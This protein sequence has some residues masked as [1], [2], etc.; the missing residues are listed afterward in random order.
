MQQ[1][2]KNISKERK[3]TSL[4]SLNEDL[5]VAVWQN[6]TCSNDDLWNNN[7]MIVNFFSLQSTHKIFERQKSLDIMLFW[8]S[9]ADRKAEISLVQAKTISFM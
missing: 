2:R 3:K 1:T 4:V 8:Y 7:Q 9:N 6:D 5:S